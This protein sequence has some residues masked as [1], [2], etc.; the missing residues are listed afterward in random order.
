M[1][2]VDINTLTM[3]QYLA[4]PRE[5][6]VPGMLKPE[7]GGNVN[8]EIKSQFM[9]ELRED[10]FFGN[11]DEDAHDHIDRV[12]SIVGLFNIPGVTKDVDLL[13]KAFIQRYCPSTMTAKQLEDIHNFKQEGDESLY[14]AWERYNDLLY[15]CTA[16]D[17]NSHQKGPIPGMR[18][19]EALTAIQTVADHSQKWH[20]GTTSRNIRSSS[21]NDGLVVLVNKLDNLGRDMKKLKES[22]HAIQV[23]CQNCEGP[24]LDKDYPLNEEVKQVE[25]I[26]N[27]PPYGKKRQSLEE[28]LA[29]HQEES[30]RRSTEMEVWI[31]K[32]Q[33]NAEINT[34]N[35]SASLKN[36]ETH[37][38][39]L[40][41]EIHYDKTLDSS[42]EQIKTITVD[43]ETSG[44]NKLH[45]VSFISD[46]ESD[47]TEVLQHQLP[48][49]ELN[50]GNFTL[51]C[52]IDKFNFYAMA[53]L[54]ASIN[55]MPRSI[56]EHL[57]LTNLRKTNMLCEMADMSKKAPLR[58]VENVLVKI[59]KFVFLSDFIIIDNTPSKTTILR[60]PLLATIRAEIDVFA[61][62]IS[63]GI[64]EDRISF[65]SMR[66]SHKYTNPSE[67]IF[68]VRPQSPAQSNN[69]IDYK[70]S[71]NLDNRSPNLDDREPKKQKIK[72]D[73]NVPRAH[74]CSLIKQNIKEQTKMW[75]SCDPNKKMCDGG[76]EIYRESKTGNLR[77]FDD[78]KWEFNLEIDKLADEYALGIG[79]KGHILDHVWKYCN[80]VHN[81]NY[82]WH[83][84]E[85]ENEECEKIGIEDK[86]YHPPEVQVET[87]KVKKYSLKGGQSFIC[88]TKDLDNTLPLGRKNGSKFK[89]MIRMEIANNKT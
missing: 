5:N 45:G 88:V 44:L 35:Q 72:L 15:K 24:H 36:L 12:L 55:V 40:T 73:K 21:S 75:P 9:R 61:G 70:E 39:Q 14:Q 80:Q 74:F 34:R 28:L 42:S 85:F 71:G 84:Y 78:Y 68:M 65:D 43:Q 77:S 79:K 64:N 26:D 48:R 29:K 31:K 76:V 22:V 41:K 6:H 86:D 25:E 16:H 2:S 54:G 59:G 57:H 13:K 63:L 17:I 51:P 27:R 82:E 62:K 8:F 38:E 49:K 53:D 87:F 47:T 56:F 23:G 69:Q 19:V 46:P 10:T 20:D 81:K 30:A 58:I 1:A 7:I 67:R 33:E 18:P 52:T 11:K 50:P 89:E 60:R 32:L 83:N 66:N 4:L 37:I 3:K